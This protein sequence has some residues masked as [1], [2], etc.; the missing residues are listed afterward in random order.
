MGPTGERVAAVR[1]SVEVQQQ[2]VSDLVTQSHVARVAS[3]ALARRARE[4]ADDAWLLQQEALAA[5][6]RSRTRR[7]S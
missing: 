6:D 7:R 5:L 1:R 2:Q 4:L 3:G